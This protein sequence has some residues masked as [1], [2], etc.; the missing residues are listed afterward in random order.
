MK[1]KLVAIILAIAIAATAVTS[2]FVAPS[3][4]QGAAVKNKQIENKVEKKIENKIKKKIKKKEIENK[5]EK[6]ATEKMDKNSK[7]G[8]KGKTKPPA[9]ET[10][11]I[12]LE[13]TTE[14]STEFVP[15]I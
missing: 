5:L 2:Y 12:I 13:P 14:T 6:K 11:D 4:L 3:S 10:T 7:K 1:K 8:K 15:E 9:T